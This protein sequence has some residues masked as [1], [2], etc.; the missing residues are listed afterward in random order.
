M[1]K[2]LR[3]FETEYDRLMTMLPT[4]KENNQRLKAVLKEK[5]ET[6]LEKQQQF[7]NLTLKIKQL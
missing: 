4:T 2:S 6:L 7:T 3:N 5:H 1:M